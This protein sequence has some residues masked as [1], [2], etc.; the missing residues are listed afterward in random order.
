MTAASDW[1]LD[2]AFPQASIQYNNQ[3]AK[4]EHGNKWFKWLATLVA[5]RPVKFTGKSWTSSTLRS[6]SCSFAERIRAPSEP[7]QRGGAA[8]ATSVAYR[9]HSRRS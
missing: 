1:L 8:V 6:F 4:L 5:L 9:P 2:E 7:L 3:E